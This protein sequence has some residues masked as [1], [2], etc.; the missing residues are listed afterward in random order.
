[1]SSYVTFAELKIASAFDQSQW[2][3]LDARRPATVAAWLEQAQAEIDDPLRLRYLVPFA[4]T[5]PSLDPDP[6]KAPRTAKRWL[7]WLMDELFQAARREAGSLPGEDVDLAARAQ[8]A[9]D[10]I[11]A[12]ADQDR[13]AHP[14]LPLRSDTRASGVS[15]GGPQMSGVNTLHGFFD[16]QAARRDQEGW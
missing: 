7:V 2:D 12:A 1:M 14:E 3:E 16:A 8:R 5:L 11:A 13:A 6:A 4:C 10:A 9:R 15:K